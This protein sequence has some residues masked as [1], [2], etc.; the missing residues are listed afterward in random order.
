MLKKHLSN[1]PISSSFCRSDTFRFQSKNLGYISK[2]KIRH[3]GSVK[4][5]EWRLSKVS[6][7]PHTKMF[8]GT[9]SKLSLIL[10][11]MFK[12]LGYII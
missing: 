4:S 11:Q 10:K 12:S 9:V 8:L 1:V 2:L 6:N 7:D 3:D 5:P